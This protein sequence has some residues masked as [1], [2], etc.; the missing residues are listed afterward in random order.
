MQ[1]REKRVLVIGGTGHIGSYLVPRLLAFG[2]TIYVFSQGK[3]R[4]YV[5]HPLWERVRWIK[6]NREE[7]EKRGTLGDL[8]QSLKLDALVDLIAFEPESA[9]FLVEALENSETHLLMCTTAWVYGKTRS[10]PTQEN[11]P[12]FPENEYARKK[13]EIEDILWEAKGKVRS[14]II[15]P[16]HITGP[17]KSFVTPFGDHNVETLQKILNGEEIILLDGGFSTLHH[18]HPKDVAELFFLAL[19]NPQKSVGEAF[20]CGGRYALTFF[21]LA[22]FLFRLVEKPLRI[23]SMSLE[24]YASQFGYP[25]EAAMHVRQGCCVS[26]EKARSLL[27]FVPAYTPEGAVTEAFYDLIKRGVLTKSS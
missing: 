26:M 1:L 13:V 3:T 22:E 19:E 21:G 10:V 5:D 17:G 8:I 27:D 9:K 11:A 14:T 15:R 12:R 6:G 18:V 2:Y 25:E 23:R 20:N 24:E 4:P 7:E 16:T